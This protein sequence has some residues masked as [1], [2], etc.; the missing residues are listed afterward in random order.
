LNLYTF[1]AT[2][3]PVAPFNFS[4]SLEFL[5]DFS[6]MKDEQDVKSGIFTKAVQTNGKT[7]AF[8]ISDKGTI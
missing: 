5:S 4:K 1:E 8:E 6:P 7:I 2:L 3:N